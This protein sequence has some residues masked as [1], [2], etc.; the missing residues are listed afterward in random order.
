MLLDLLIKMGYYSLVVHRIW[1]EVRDQQGYAHSFIAKSCFF[2][3][4]LDMKT[5]NQNL[6]DIMKTVAADIDFQ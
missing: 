4:F 5:K 3:T 2:N 6:I 1:L